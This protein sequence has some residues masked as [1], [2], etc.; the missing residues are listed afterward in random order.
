MST[1]I[2]WY[3]SPAAQP[4]VT[5]IPNFQLGSIVDQVYTASP[6]SSIY[7]I[8]YVD[9]VILYISPNRSSY[10]YMYVY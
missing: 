1:W 6:A 7:L 5:S 9:I 2:S 4:G 8:N 3:T 10:S